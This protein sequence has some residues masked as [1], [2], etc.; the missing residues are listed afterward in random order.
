[1]SYGHD[2]YSAN[3]SRTI[4]EFLNHIDGLMYK[5]K[6]ERRRTSDANSTEQK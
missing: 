3:D 2:V 4:D 6:E 1:M 5:H